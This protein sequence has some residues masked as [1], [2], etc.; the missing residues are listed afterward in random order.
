[1]IIIDDVPLT[2]NEIFDDDLITFLDADDLRTDETI[3]RNIL[4]L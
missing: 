4:S 1:L 3:G 2:I